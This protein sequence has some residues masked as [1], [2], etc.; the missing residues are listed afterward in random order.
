MSLV[1]VEKDLLV[2]VEQFREFVN[3]VIKEFG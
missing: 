3:R 1:K 2:A